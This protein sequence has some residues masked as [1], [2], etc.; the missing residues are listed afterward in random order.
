MLGVSRRIRIPYVIS[1]PGRMGEQMPQRDRLLRWPQLRLALLVES[2]ED[3]RRLEFGKQLAHW[4]V[5]LQLAL[6]DELHGGGRR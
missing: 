6:L 3:L 5:K 4:L 2:L 1:E